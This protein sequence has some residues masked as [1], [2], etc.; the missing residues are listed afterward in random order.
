VDILQEGLLLPVKLLKS[1]LILLML[2]NGHFKTLLV[3][4]GQRI[5]GREKWLYGM[6]QF[7]LLRMSRGRYERDFRNF[8]D[9]VPGHGLILD[10]G[11]NL[12]VMSAYLA[13]KKDS[14]RI[15]AIEPIPL[16]VKVMSKLFKH[17]RIV[18]VEIVEKA[19]SNKNGFVE[20]KVPLRNGVLQHGLASLEIDNETGGDIYQ[21]SAI[22]LD[23]LMENY[24]D[25][26]LVGVKIDVE[27]HEWEVL[28]GGIQTI[29][30]YYPIIMAE[31][32]N[33]AKKQDCLSLMRS[34]GYRVMYVNADGGLVVYQGED[35][36]NYLFIPPSIK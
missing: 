17:K 34:L 10:I 2:K 33:D 9:L 19:L 27:N 4:A 31:L 3:K 15:I 7:N 14:L 24:S 26:I 23:Q 16:H 28:S 18:N 21:V 6:A 22:T 35:V 29:Q 11:A 13:Q 25:E 32:W 30:K 5:F 12:G 1:Y 20:M 36:L 8:A